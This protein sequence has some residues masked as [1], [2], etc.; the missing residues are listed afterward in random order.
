[1]RLALTLVLLGLPRL[2]ARAQDLLPEGPWNNATTIDV[3][4]DPRL[5]RLD[6]RESVAFTN[7]GTAPVRELQFHLYPNAFANDGVLFQVERRR[8][9]DDDPLA[10]LGSDQLGYCAIQQATIAGQPVEPSIDGT[11]MTIPLAAPLAPGSTVTVNLVFVT[12]LPSTEVSGRMGWFANHF[13]VE[14]R[15]DLLPDDAQLHLR[16]PVAHAAMDAEAKR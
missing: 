2:A 9:L 13:D 10:G 15:Q 4:L 5:Q 3:T 16:Q 6:G 14:P 7:R 8:A 1:M 11:V 12:K